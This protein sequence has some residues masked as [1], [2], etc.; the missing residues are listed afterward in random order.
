M[1]A[2]CVETVAS[3]CQGVKH[4][5]EGLVRLFNAGQ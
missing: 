3:C 5:S 2:N 1:Q 4:S